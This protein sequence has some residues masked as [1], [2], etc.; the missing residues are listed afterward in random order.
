[1]G[2]VL[3]GHP[4]NCR[5]LV[6]TALLS[7]CSCCAQLSYFSREKARVME[8]ARFLRLS[9]SPIF[10]LNNSLWSLEGKNTPHPSLPNN[11]PPIPAF[12]CSSAELSKDLW[13]GPHSPR[14]CPVKS[15]LS[16]STTSKNTY[17]YKI[18]CFC[19]GNFAKQKQRRGGPIEGGRR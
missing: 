1:M 16:C 4:W 9:R 18:M 11:K 19:R 10:T 7:E 2:L 15:R 5:D 3:P 13:H 8:G 12:L 14:H 6:V 17:F